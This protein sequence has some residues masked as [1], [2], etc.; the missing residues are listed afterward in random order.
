MR[1]QKGQSRSR[2][3]PETALT[4]VLCAE[5]AYSALRKLQNAEVEEFWVLALGPAK[6]LLRC[7]MIF[8]GTVDACLVH[9]RD[10]FRFACSE[11]ASSLIVAHNHPSGDLR[12]SPEDLAITRRL[13]HASVI[14]EI[15]L[16]DHL[17]LADGR[18]ASFARER[19]CDF[20]LENQR[21]APPED[22][23]I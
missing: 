23:M 17:L 15:P 8:R 1:N 5:L 10:I 4:N 3:L 6:S 2:P 22:F 16:V 11:N 18:F 14:L 21:T 13:I 12:P 9:P 19:W 7:K 20:G